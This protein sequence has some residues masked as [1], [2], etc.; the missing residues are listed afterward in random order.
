[1]TNDPKTAPETFA[2]VIAVWASAFAM[3]R[4]VGEENGTVQKWKERNNIRG[5]H[6][7]RIVR[8]AKKRSQARI[9]Y[10]DG[11]DKITLQLLADIAERTALGSN[12]KR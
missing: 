4:D 7:N 3:A 5:E 11:Y 1:M 9:V 12:R 6:W 10:R 2:E 8:A